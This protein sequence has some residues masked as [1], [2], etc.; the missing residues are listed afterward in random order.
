MVIGVDEA[1]M[2]AL[3]R[4]ERCRDS[5]TSLSVGEGLSCFERRWL[6]GRTFPELTVGAIAD[7]LPKLRRLLVR[8]VSGRAEQ[9][10]GK[11]KHAD[12]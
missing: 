11:Q 6:V 12:K 10:G 9:D 5:Q 7:R 8:F 2:H 1:N 3:A 4:L